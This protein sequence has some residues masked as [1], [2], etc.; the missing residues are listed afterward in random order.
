MVD[1]PTPSNSQQP[2]NY[3]NASTCETSLSRSNAEIPK[4]ETSDASTQ[5]KPEK[6]KIDVGVYNVFNA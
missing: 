5:Q 2:L 6:K 1:V 3:Q 4:K